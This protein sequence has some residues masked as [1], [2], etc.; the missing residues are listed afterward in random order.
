MAASPE[1]T[2]QV[3]TKRS[4]RMRSLVGRGKFGTDGFADMVD[5]AM[6]EFTHASLDIWPLLNVWLGVSA[7]NQE[8]ADRRIPDLLITPAAVRWVSAE[9]LLGPV[10]LDQPQCDAHGRDFISDDGQWCTECSADGFSGELSFGH[11]LDPLNGGIQWVVTGG[12]SGPGARPMHLDW[13]RSVRDQCATAG[14]PFLFKQWGAWTPVPTG[15]SRV[16]DVWVRPDGSAV[17]MLSARAEDVP[18]GS[19]LMR[20]VG[21]KAAGRHL[22]GRVH[23]GYPAT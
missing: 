23:D 8:G 6:A 21:K 17:G 11:W 15:E 22:D 3:L 13:A 10:D 12:E 19:V 7:E 16:A 2:Y 4:A 5:E 9:P 18:L 1:H 20:Q 14:V